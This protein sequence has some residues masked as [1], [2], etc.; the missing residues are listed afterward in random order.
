VLGIP[1]EHTC[2]VSGSL[3]MD[4]EPAK[5]LGVPEVWMQYPQ[6]LAE[7]VHPLKGRSTRSISRAWGIWR[8]L[9]S[10]SMYLA[11]IHKTRGRG[12]GRLRVIHSL[13]RGWMT[14]ANI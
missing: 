4:L 6:S 8:A 14:P 7:N 13:T 1:R 10:R 9:S 5:E 12:L 11:R 3:L 2:V